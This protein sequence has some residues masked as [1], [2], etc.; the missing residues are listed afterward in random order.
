MVL[1]EEG[2]DGVGAETETPPLE[3][4]NCL[5][6]DEMKLSSMVYISGHTE[7]INNGNRLNMGQV[8]NRDVETN[9]V[10]IGGCIFIYKKMYSIK[11]SILNMKSS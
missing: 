1:S 6:Y 9:A 3:L 8:R 4:R 7:C 10:I 11:R 5:S 2:W